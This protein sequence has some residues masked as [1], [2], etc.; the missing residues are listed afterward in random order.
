[1]PL[2]TILEGEPISFDKM[3]VQENPRAA[4]LLACASQSEG[5]YA[6]SPKAAAVMA[7][8]PSPVNPSSRPMTPDSLFGEI[9]NAKRVV[10][11]VPD[12]LIPPIFSRCMNCWRKDHHTNNP[13]NW[14]GKCGFE[15]IRVYWEAEY[16]E[17]LA[18]QNSRSKAQLTILAASYYQLQ[19]SYD[20]IL[21]RL[22]Q[23]ELENG[24]LRAANTQLHA[25]N[26]YLH[27]RRSLDPHPIMEGVAGGSGFADTRKGVLHRRR[28]ARDTGGSPYLS[29]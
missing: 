3:P 21:T 24:Q 4:P 8:L 2:P 5:K 9:S 23:L 27:H 12:K 19:A 1:M 14:S 26:S 25:D 7:A 28:M 13:S 15:Q 11:P 29:P 6:S 10:C 16:E 22:H 20:D 18:R 17:E